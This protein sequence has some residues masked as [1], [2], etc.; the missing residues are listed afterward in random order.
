MAPR[1]A[2]MAALR[3]QGFTMDELVVELR[4]MLARGGANPT[5]VDIDNRK[6]AMEYIRKATEHEEG[7][8]VDVRLPPKDYPEVV[9]RIEAIFERMISM[10]VFRPEAKALLPSILATAPKMTEIPSTK[11]EE[12]VRVEIQRFV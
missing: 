10:G 12:A 9:Q 7:M 8:L 2:I 3:A 11:G 6:W 1:G 4:D 5:P